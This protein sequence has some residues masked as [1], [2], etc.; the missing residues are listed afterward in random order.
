[1]GVQKHVLEIT[2]S[3]SAEKMF[4]GLVIDMYSILAKVAPGAYKHVE[5]IGD[6]GAGTIKHITLPDGAP[7]T[8][9]TVRTDAIDKK[10]RTL[11]YSA[12]GGDILM[13]FLDKIENHVVVVPNADG[14]STTTTT[15]IYHTKGDAVVPE[16]NIKYADQ[17][18]T[19]LFKVVEAYVIAN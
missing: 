7:I 6:G 3:V 4:Q 8:T 1:M 9:M 2:S 12:I 14:G 16:E 18:N 15:A 11:D 10:A 19:L 17:Q 5:T 13:G